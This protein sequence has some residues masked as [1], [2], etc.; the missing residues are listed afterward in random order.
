MI[1]Q[2]EGGQNAKLNYRASTAVAEKTCKLY[3]PTS[4]IGTTGRIYN[5]PVQRG[6][7]RRARVHKNVGQ[8]WSTSSAD[9]NS[10]PKDTFRVTNA[11]AIE[12][13]TWPAR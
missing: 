2:G 9:L 3:L 4:M 7:R 5:S 10:F 1:S 12:P 8:H 6:A 13:L 11:K